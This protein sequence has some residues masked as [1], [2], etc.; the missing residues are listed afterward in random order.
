MQDLSPNSTLYNPLMPE[1]STFILF[2]CELQYKTFLEILCMRKGLK[3]D[4]YMMW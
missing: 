3:C 1:V 4:T 2:S